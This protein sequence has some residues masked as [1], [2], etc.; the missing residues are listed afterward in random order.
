[1]SQK[2]P[3]ISSRSSQKLLVSD[4]EK[5]NKLLKDYIQNQ[6]NFSNKD[7]KKLIENEILKQFLEEKLK[8]SKKEIKKISKSKEKEILLPVSIFKNK[9]ST[10]EVVVKY[11]KEKKEFNFVEISRLLNRDER[12]IWH[13]YQRTVKKKI[14]IV[15]SKTVSPGSKIKIPVSIFFKRIYSPLESLVAHLKNSQKFKL[16]EIAVML[17]LSPKTIWTVYSRYK[18]KK[19]RKNKDASK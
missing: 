8:I 6:L 7:I 13:A 18:R 2:K 4:S 10:L 1:M 16:T 3:H 14:K 11:L 17:E 12:T 9:L 19:E 5:E 15:D